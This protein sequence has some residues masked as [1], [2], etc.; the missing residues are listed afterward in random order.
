M[1]RGKPSSTNPSSLG[2]ALADEVDH[3]VVRNEVAALEDRA[4]LRAELRPSDDR[5]T[6]DVAG[7]D[8]RH[9]V[10]CGDPLRL[11]PLAGAL[12]ARE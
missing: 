3:E 1:V 11:G 9:V 12:R 7:R 4:H 5:G 2:E 6:Q 8:V 10:R